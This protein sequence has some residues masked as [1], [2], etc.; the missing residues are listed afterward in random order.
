MEFHEYRTIRDV[1]KQVVPKHVVK[2]NPD[3]LYEQLESA[4]SD[5]LWMQAADERRWEALKRP[6]YNLYP[7]II[8]MLTRLNLDLESD[9]VRLPMD[10]LCVR[11]P[12][13]PAKNPL[14]FDWK[15]ERVHVCCIL[16]TD[17]DAKGSLVHIDL[18]SG[19]SG[20]MTLHP[21]FVLPRKPGVSLEQLL[22]DADKVTVDEHGR[23]T[24]P[25]A[26]LTDCLRLFCT[27]CLLD[28][29]PEVI[30]PDVLADDRMW[31]EA[32]GDKKFVDKAHRRGKVGWDVGR[33]IEKIPHIRRPH[34]ALVWT[35]KGRKI[36]KI[37][38]RKGS[39]VHREK[40]ETIPT[41][42]LG[43]AG[44][45]MEAPVPNQQPS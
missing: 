14:Q 16:A 4:G 34:M 23:I 28:E 18:G 1:T 9:L 20:R 10:S 36:R 40:V 24:I 35:G 21:Y 27:L 2:H 42:F 32:T 17:L 15:G 25:D 13:D 33:H 37:V 8:P 22:T 12:K 41:G 45:T 19:K 30:S 11:F 5:D 31:Y 29:D 6:Y 7:S 26:L 3:W 44:Y 43:D 39:V 38:P